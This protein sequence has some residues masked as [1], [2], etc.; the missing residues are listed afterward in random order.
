ML[1]WTENGSMLPSLNQ[2]HIL[3]SPKQLA[4]RYFFCFFFKYCYCILFSSMP[5]PH[6]FINWSFVNFMF[7]GCIKWLK[8]LKFLIYDD[9]PTHFY[10]Y[11]IAQRYWLY[12]V[13]RFVYDIMNCLNLCYG[14]R[15]IIT[16]TNLEKKYLKQLCVFNF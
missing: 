16:K 1:Y 11:K 2:F 8:L 13:S 10:I 12:Q 15:E 9:S 7:T 5:Q 4:R 14:S 3:K 6:F